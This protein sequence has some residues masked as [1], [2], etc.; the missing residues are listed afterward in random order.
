HFFI[1]TAIA[2]VCHS[3]THKSGDVCVTKTKTKKANQEPL[4]VA[5]RTFRT[6]TGFHHSIMGL[7]IIRQSIDNPLQPC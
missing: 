7:K 4:V 5:L 6:S 2:L 3:L 1:V